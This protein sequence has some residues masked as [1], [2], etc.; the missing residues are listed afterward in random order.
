ML[1]HLTV[2]VLLA[3]APALA[4]DA[5]NPPPTEGAAGLEGQFVFSQSDGKA[6]GCQVILYAEETAGHYK[7]ELAPDCKE[8]FEFLGAVTG[9]DFDDQDIVLVGAQDAV[10]IQLSPDANG[11][12]RGKNEAD[13]RD[14]YLERTSG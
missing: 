2:A 4:D 7:A 14:Y 10:V 1:K 13:G 5:P 8:Q 11:M 9:W 12:L 3:L 6:R